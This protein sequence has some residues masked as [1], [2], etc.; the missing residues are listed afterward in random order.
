MFELPKAYS[1]SPVPEQETV[2]GLQ[3]ALVL[4]GV[5]ICLPAF[6]TGAELAAAL[7]GWRGLAAVF[8]AGLVL[9]AIACLTGLIGH[10]LRLSSYMIILWTFGHRAGKAVNLLVSLSVLGWYGVLTGMFAKSAYT[11]V[12]GLFAGGAP[13]T[14]D[15]GILFWVFAGSALM[16]GTTIFGFRA[17]S[18]LSQFATPLMVALLAWVVFRAARE[19][20]S[21]LMTAGDGTLSLS[22]GISIATGGLII[23]ATLMPDLAR[24][25]RRRRDVLIAAFLGYGVGFPLVLALAG[26][27]AIATGEKDLILVM[28]M[29]GLGTAAMAILILS[30]WTT[31]AFNLY[32]CTLVMGTILPRWKSW[33]LTI[34]AGAVGTVLCLGGIGDAVVPYLSLL[35]ALIPPIAAV[36]LADYWI[37]RRTSRDV[38]APG[39][40]IRWRAVLSCA[41]GA[42]FA[43]SADRYQFSVTQLVPLDA[44]LS[45]FMIYVAA[46]IVPVPGG[47]DRPR[48]HAG[49]PE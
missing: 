44:A 10:R 19:S 41:A 25:A 42:A 15:H 37:V 39:P 8:G 33:V 27:P 18:R 40:A 29:L 12:Q 3:I 9:T 30:T 16:V 48:V 11:L 24:F 2:G 35:S 21:I 28:T 23:G 49:L 13:A 38:A 1:T 7:G 43:F 31:N 47:A 17:L 20:P 32:V 22:R 45:A 46:A 36:Y 4:I 26:I 14:G 34:A 5:A 6:I